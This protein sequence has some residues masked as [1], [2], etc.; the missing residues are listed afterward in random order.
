MRGLR[1]VSP[2]QLR[3]ERRSVAP[4]RRPA[5]PLPPEA[6]QRA[7][8][9]APCI[10][11]PPPAPHPGALLDPTAAGGALP[12]GAAP[13]GRGAR[14]RPRTEGPAAQPG[15]TATR[16]SRRL[17]PSR[18]R[19]HPGAVRQILC[20]AEV[21]VRAKPGEA[22]QQ[23]TLPR[24][25]PQPAARRVALLGDPEQQEFRFDAVHGPAESQEAVTAALGDLCGHVADGYDAAVVVVGTAGS[26]R[27]YT[28]FGEAGDEGIAPRL[29]ATLCSLADDFNRLHGPQGHELALSVAMAD[30]RPGEPPTD[31]LGSPGGTV[32]GEGSLSPGARRTPQ[33][34]LWREASGCADGLRCALAAAAQRAAW[35]QPR[36]EGCCMA[37]LRARRQQLD[38]DAAGG[39]RRAASSL[40]TVAELRPADPAGAAEALRQAAAGL[41]E[42]AQPAGQHAAQGGRTPSPPA[43]ASPLAHALRACFGPGTK[44]VVLACV[45][46]SPELYGDTVRMLRAVEPLAELRSLCGVAEP[47]PPHAE[48]AAQLRE[49]LTSPALHPSEQA[50][51]AARLRYELDA[52]QDRDRRHL[53]L[54]RRELALEDARRATEQAAASPLSSPPR[55]AGSPPSPGSPRHLSPLRSHAEDRVFAPSDQRAQTAPA[56]SVMRE[57]PPA[58]ALPGERRALWSPARAARS[59]CSSGGPPAAWEADPLGPGS[60]PPAPAPAPAVTF[61]V[62]GGGG[63]EV[64]LTLGGAGA[65]Q[66]LHYCIVAADGGCPPPR[67]ADDMAAVLAAG[68]LPEGAVAAG[69]LL[70]GPGSALGTDCTTVALPTNVDLRPG[71]Q[72]LVACAAEPPEGDAPLACAVLPFA[73]GPPRQK[74]AATGRR[75]S[76]S[77]LPPCSGGLRELVHRT[78]EAL[79]RAG[80]RGVGLLEAALRAACLGA[81]P[82]ERAALSCAAELEAAPADAEGAAELCERVAP[83]A[84]ALA[85]AHPHSPLGACAREVCSLLAQPSPG[86]LE[87]AAARLR[88]E[89][90]RMQQ[91]RAAA[92]AARAAG[93]LLRTD[94]ASERGGPRRGA[95]ASALRRAAAAL[96]GEEAGGAAALLRHAAHAAETAT[97]DPDALAAAAGAADAASEAAARAGLAGAQCA[98]AAARRVAEAAEGLLSGVVAGSGDCAGEAAALEEEAAAAAEACGGCGAAA[99]GLASSAAAL[100]SAADLLQRG[101]ARSEAVAQLGLASSAARG[102]ERAQGAAA[103]AAELLADAAARRRRGDEQGARESLR[104]AAQLAP[105]LKHADDGLAERLRRAETEADPSAL[106]QALRA[107]AGHP[108]ADHEAAAA[109]A[110]VLA[111]PP[112]PDADGGASESSASAGAEPARRGSSAPTPRRASRRGMPR[113]WCRASAARS[114]GPSGG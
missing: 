49:A 58:Q 18:S 41:W 94:T 86:G 89:A 64:R 43:A 30:M 68:P 32:E 25:L 28:A 50:A 102:G 31:L 82:S 36:H 1:S 70:G 60:V 77:P 76:V 21:V 84:A 15:P 46:T 59:P 51:L 9:A 80:P 113:P 55:R 96:G 33:R 62:E 11:A 12:R 97:A 4:S 87:Q 29:A 90:G 19:A 45:D 23:Q 78:G 88:A 75:E 47:N 34:A 81:G 99:A 66:R 83:R 40:L 48:R 6:P 42:V 7:Y 5:Y 103:H 52:L 10:S 20:S 57:G 22:A 93:W 13:R 91:A 44:L 71:V 85:A 72:Y 24:V 14:S 67:T 111:Y 37:L 69:T 8:S 35:R 65:L 92:A 53:A 16:R 108:S 38:P 74:A 63:R 61:A 27:T 114:W 95:A 104:S 110:R 105:G 98:A 56:R 2:E 3:P 101:G 79:C 26:G 112:A 109:L 39:D 100:R 106:R 17:S 73:A 54:S 107:L